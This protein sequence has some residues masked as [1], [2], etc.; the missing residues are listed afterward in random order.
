M[1]V[2]KYAQLPQDLRNAI[3]TNEG[4]I[5]S[6]FDPYAPGSAETIRKS[7]L[8]ATTG[9]VTLS[10]AAKFRDLGQDIDHCPKK[11]K[12]L[13]EIESW[14]CRLGGTALTVTRS[15]APLQFGAV[16]E[17]ILE[18]EDSVMI[19]KPRMG[20]KPTDFKTLW[21]VCAYGT[22]GG[23]IAV[24]L[25]NALNEA[26]F[27]MRAENGKKGRFAFSYAAYS[28]VESPDEVPFTFFLKRSGKDTVEQVAFDME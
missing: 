4:L 21:Y 25:E 7:I 18:T 26:G 1:S 14:E 27:S 15:N 12:E 16:D 24:K 17:K 23:F 9:G 11:T 22:E 3:T 8:Y 5:L 28:S 2:K 19:L 20:V 6:D 13:L 10:C